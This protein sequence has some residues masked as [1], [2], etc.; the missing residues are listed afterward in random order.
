MSFLIELRVSVFRNGVTVLNLWWRPR[1][2]F[3]GAGDV[4]T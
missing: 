4:T 3:G 2:R 1:Q